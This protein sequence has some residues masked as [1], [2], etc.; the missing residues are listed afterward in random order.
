MKKCFI[1]EKPVTD[2]TGEKLLQI[3]FGWL[4]TYA[5]KT[6]EK[7]AYHL[8]DVWWGSFMTRERVPNNGSD[9]C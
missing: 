6:V 3:M 1:P 9:I 2:Q 7:S 4:Q 5:S 8:W